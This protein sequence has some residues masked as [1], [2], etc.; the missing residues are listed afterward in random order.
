MVSGAN[1]D[2]T[3]S[4]DRHPA[5]AMHPAPSQ[6]LDKGQA[7]VWKISVT[8]TQRAQITLAAKH[9]NIPI[10]LFIHDRA[11]NGQAAARR[12]WA[13]GAARLDTAAARIAALA[14][15]LTQAT[16]PQDTVAILAALVSLERSLDR[17]ARPWLQTSD[18]A[19]TPDDAASSPA[20]RATGAA[21]C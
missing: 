6:A 20:S 21:S 12:D 19:K 2:M 7:Q 8:P 1:M 10:G 4:T 17:I 11:T 15:D 5:N 14:S 18:V 9:A 3:R 16:S 13:L